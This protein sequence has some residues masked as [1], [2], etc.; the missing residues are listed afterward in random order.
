MRISWWLLFSIFS[1][2]RSLPHR[3][4]LLY[5][6]TPLP[7]YTAI[8][9]DFVEDSDD[10][11]FWVYRRWVQFVLSVTP[12]PGAVQRPPVI[13]SNIV[14]STGAQ[15]HPLPGLPNKYIKT[16]CLDGRTPEE[17][18]LV[19]E[20]K[21]E[22]TQYMQNGWHWTWTIY[23]W[24]QEVSEDGHWIFACQEG[25][26]AVIEERQNLLGQPDTYGNCV[27]PNESESTDTS[28]DA[29]PSEIRSEHEADSRQFPRETFSAPRSTY[30]FSAVTCQDVPSI[31]YSVVS[32]FIS[33]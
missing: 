15:L 18:I 16:S 22:D 33:E 12:I 14:Q 1:P 28:D 7:G 17:W 26:V 11:C 32:L 5:H 21:A 8:D 20:Y 25:T 2:T 6:A 10:L 9:K 4:Q 27:D 3:Q 19:N 29:E 24:Y 30:T 13:A 23:K 31:S